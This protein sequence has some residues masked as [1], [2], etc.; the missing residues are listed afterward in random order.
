MSIRPEFDDDEDDED[1][2][3]PEVSTSVF[4]AYLQLLRLSNVFTAMADVLL[5]FLVVERGFLQFDRLALLLGSS[6][7]LYLAGMVLNDVFDRETDAAERPERP[8]PAGRISAETA[9]MLGT[10]LLAGGTALGWAAS[11][12]IGELR[13]GI[14]ATVLAVAVLAYD[15]VLKRTPLGPLAM[16]T[17]RALNVLLG[18]SANDTGWQTIHFVIAGGIG[19]YV[20]GLTWFARTEAKQSDRLQ[21]RLAL[22]VMLAALAMLS[23]LPVWKDQLEPPVVFPQF[24]YF[25]WGLIA[26]GVG[27]RCMLAISTPTPELVQIAVSNGI[28]ALIVIDAASSTPFTETAAAAVILLLMIPARVLGRWIYST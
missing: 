21:L 7:L 4:M 13:P 27:T 16:G 22:G 5:G 9:A 19:L 6:S 15:R 12:T 3:S 1:D 17:C 28:L 23:Q 2:D 24:W 20:V 18:M 10:V 14:V 25:F 11:Y 8:I 26:I